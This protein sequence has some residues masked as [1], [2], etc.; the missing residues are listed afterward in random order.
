MKYINT[1]KEISLAQRVPRKLLK[2]QTLSQKFQNKLADAQTC[3]TTT[4]ES[5]QQ[6]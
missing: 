2:L 4:A 3:S 1:N 6:K 5:H